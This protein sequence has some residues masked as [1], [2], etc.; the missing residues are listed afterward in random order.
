MC[1]PWRE[2]KDPDHNAPWDFDPGAG[3]PGV[4]AY[5]FNPSTQEEFET[6]VVYIVSSRAAWATAW[7]TVSEKKKDKKEKKKI[8]EKGISIV[9]WDAISTGSYREKHCWEHSVKHLM[10]LNNPNNCSLEQECDKE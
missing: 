5:S 10:F 9:S 3:K 4:M 6:G 7:N 8:F 2:L 1:K